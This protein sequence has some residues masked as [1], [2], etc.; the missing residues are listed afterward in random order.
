MGA[1]LADYAAG[2]IMVAVIAGGIWLFGMA[3]SD[4]D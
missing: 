2:W 3:M 4:D 1:W